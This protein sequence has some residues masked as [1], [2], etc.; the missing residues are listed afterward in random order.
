MI[1]KSLEDNYQRWS[2]AIKWHKRDVKHQAHWSFGAADTK[3]RRP[4]AEE[5]KGEHRIGV[6]YRNLMEEAA[7]AD[8]D[9]VEKLYAKSKRAHERQ[10]ELGAK[11][12][13]ICRDEGLKVQCEAWTCLGE[14]HTA[15][16]KLLKQEQADEGESEGGEDEALLAK[17][18]VLN[19]K[20]KQ[21]SEELKAAAA[22]ERAL[23]TTSKMGAVVT[24]AGRDEEPVS[25]HFLAATAH[26][27]LGDVRMEPEPRRALDHILYAI[28]RLGSRDA[29]GAWR[30]NDTLTKGE[31]TAAKKL[32]GLNEYNLAVVLKNLHHF[33]RGRV[34]AHHSDGEVYPI[35]QKSAVELGLEA[36]NH[37]ASAGGTAEEKRESKRQNQHM[38]GTLYEKQGDLTSAAAHFGKG[39][40]ADAQAYNEQMARDAAQAKAK[41][42]RITNGLLDRQR[43]GHAV[44][45]DEVKRLSEKANELEAA[46]QWAAAEQALR[47]AL[48]LLGAPDDVWN[49]RAAA[50][51]DAWQGNAW[52][53]AD[54][55]YKTVVAAASC[56]HNLGQLLADIVRPAE[57]VWHAR[58]ACAAYEAAMAAAPAA[59]EA[60]ARTQLTMN[61]L[62]AL[63]LLGNSYVED[64]QT[65][66]LQDR[67][68][69]RNEA[70]SAYTK[71]LAV[72]RVAEQ[73]GRFSS[74]RA[75]KWR[76]D[77]LDN[78]D[79]E[80]SEL[81]RQ[82]AA[83]AAAAADTAEARRRVEGRLAEI[84]KRL[85]DLF[86][87]HGLTLHEGEPPEEPPAA[88]RPAPAARRRRRRARRARGAREGRGSGGEGACG[89]GARGAREARG[90]R[91][92]GGE[93]R[94]EARCEAARGGEESASGMRRRRRRRRRRS[95]A[96]SGGRRSGARARRGAAA[97]R[98]RTPPPPPPPRARRRPLRARAGRS[99][100]SLASA[101]RRPPP[102]RRHRRRRIRR[103][104][105]SRRRPRR[106]RR[107]R[108]RRR[109]R[110]AS[111]R[112]AAVDRREHGS[113]ARRVLRAERSGV[114]RRLL[115]PAAA[116]ARREW[117]RARDEAEPRGGPVGAL[118]GGRLGEDVGGGRR[119]LGGRW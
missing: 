97:R 96:R 46:H 100:T 70:C 69:L 94:G 29:K 22:Y 67:R 72:V 4:E 26:T 73:E 49:A 102:R 118:V 30:P 110:A 61:R 83:A 1:G 101:R 63:Q 82:P 68:R 86:E 58:A 3:G 53:R 90:G 113:A 37:L 41:V 8:D 45:A 6:C 75:D 14:L 62:E 5:A 87:K 111:V 109:G 12:M 92:E 27:N 21:E 39:N 23:A 88:A 104:R 36:L 52:W 119:R 66:K 60:E 34:V 35:D 114:P 59:G 78:I 2:D 77:L 65:R 115:R 10:R 116:A 13:D 80:L 44:G 93:E 47:T 84:R 98:R 40:D 64:G 95:G 57:A 48:K 33:K 31:H 71:G 38:I 51:D 91:E 42:D 81:V 105:R 17:L 7:E 18:R 103:R 32:Q 76:A 25:R 20:R 15:R 9:D 89:G 112:A 117:R 85:R 79:S 74:A 56:H 24:P 16:A 54:A 99:R 11:L 28:S 108:C 50:E 19:L 107:S 55:D 106:R 43:K